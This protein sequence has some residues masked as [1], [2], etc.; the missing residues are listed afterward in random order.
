MFVTFISIHLVIICVVLLWRTYET[1]PAL[2]LKSECDIGI[3][4][5]SLGVALFKL[6][7][8]MDTL[9][10]PNSFLSTD[11]I[12]ETHSAYLQGLIKLASKS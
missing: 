2:P 9:S 3:G 6:R 4:Y 8:L 5:S 10:L 11:T 1:H 7:Q 12:L